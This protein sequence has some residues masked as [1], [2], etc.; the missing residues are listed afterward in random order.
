M[1][2]VLLNQISEREIDAR[3]LA[4][5]RTAL[6][7]IRDDTTDCAP[8]ICWNVEVRMHSSSP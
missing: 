8:E 3:G 4:F 6:R 5:L 2:G 1:C 7:R